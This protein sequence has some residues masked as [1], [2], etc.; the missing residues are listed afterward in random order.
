[1]KN[2]LAQLSFLAVLASISTTAN[3]ASVS[4]EADPF[5]YFMNGYSLN[6]RTL[7]DSGLDISAGI[8]GVNV[9]EHVLKDSQIDGADWRASISDGQ[10][11]KVGYKFSKPYR[12]GF[13]THLFASRQKWNVKSRAAQEKSDFTV[14]GTGVSLGYTYH[15]PKS[16]YLFPFATYAVNT[17]TEGNEKVQG[18]RYKIDSSEIGLGVNLGFEF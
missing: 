13:S 14:I 7:F 16:F 8:M 12:D 3:A 18:Y 5:A 4:L 6:V 17:I 11:L 10:L 1:M 2:T 9:P 15:L